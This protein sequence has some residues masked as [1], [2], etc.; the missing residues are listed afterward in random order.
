MDTAGMDTAGMDTAGMDTAGMD[1]AGMDT[2]GM[3]AT[4][5]AGGTRAAKSL[6]GATAGGDGCASK[7]TPNVA[8]V[9]ITVA[10]GPP[11]LSCKGEPGLVSRKNE[12]WLTRNSA[13]RPK[14]QLMPK[15]E[16]NTATIIR[17]T[18]RNIR[19]RRRSRAIRQSLPAIGLYR[20]D[21]DHGRGIVIG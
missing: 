17:R 16:A 7:R 20:H 21:L 3:D 1:T 8:A 5:A 18:F 19:P 14:A 11:L 15:T 12:S 13:N 6:S 4:G 9:L 10:G 2:A